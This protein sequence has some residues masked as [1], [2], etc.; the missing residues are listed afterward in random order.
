MVEEV[1]S[2]RESWDH[3]SAC[4]VGNHNLNGCLVAL[5]IQRVL[6]LPCCVDEGRE[7]T[8]DE[9]E[10][11]REAGIE[12]RLPGHKRA[13]ELL[14]RLDSLQHPEGEEE[15]G[16]SGSEDSLESWVVVQR[17]CESG[18]LAMERLGDLRLA[19]A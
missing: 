4:P 17:R 3:S 7:H 2:G 10:R 5:P 11:R 19:F 16:E 1:E 8:G 15:G 14:E 13:Q 6:I 18:E 12:R 9:G